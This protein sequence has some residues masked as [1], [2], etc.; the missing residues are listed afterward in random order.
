MLQAEKFAFPL[1]CLIDTP[2]ASITLEDEARGQAQAIAANLQLMIGLRVP[3]ISVIIGEGG[4]G[5]ALALGIADRLLMQ[6][7]SYYSTASPESA[8][9][10]VFRN[11]KY[12]PEMA[13]GM[14]VSARQLKQRGVVDELVPE[15]LGGAHGDMQSAARMLKETLLAQLAVLQRYTLAELLE[16]RYQKYRMAGHETIESIERSDAFARE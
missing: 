2:G 1:I 8:A 10:I 7:Y 3:V 12:A 9:L 14:Q 16:L 13:M 11:E 4:S 5:G 6:E 15:P